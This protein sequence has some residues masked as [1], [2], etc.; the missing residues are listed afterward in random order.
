MARINV[1]SDALQD[2]RIVRRLPRYSGL[3]QH[4]ALGR[5]LHVWALGYA[6]KSVE[7]TG[8]DI[9]EAADHVGFAAAMVQA[10]LAVLVS[11]EPAVYRV[12]GL[13]A[14]IGYLVAQSTA[15]KA[16]G[17]RR[18]EAPRAGG[19]FVR[20]Q[21]FHQPAAGENQPTAGEAPA[22]QNEV[23]GSHQPSTSRS[24]L[25]YSGSGSTLDLDLGGVGGAGAPPPSQPSGRDPKKLP[26]R[27]SKP[28]PV[29]TPVP[30]DFT[31]N[32]AARAMAAE[33]RLDLARE[34]ARWRDNASAKGRMWVDHQAAL[35]T[36]LRNS[37]EYRDRDLANGRATGGGN[38]APALRL[39]SQAPEF[40]PL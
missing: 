22:A 39:V 9:E 29:E 35:R 27:V 34:V 19:R 15:A 23:A 7:L 26:K 5:L 12:S 2:P 25:L 20:E 14:R 18:K 38:A 32:D 3:G 8:E 10:G 24:S 33:L 16:G 37:A 28:K 30:E 21:T 17:E 4:D 6:R 31:P 11:A 40:K 36:W 13:E 1:D